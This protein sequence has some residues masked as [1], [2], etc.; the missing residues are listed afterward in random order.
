MSGMTMGEIERL[1]KTY[2]EERAALEETAEEVRVARRKA[3][4]SKL[5]VLKS[6]AARTSEAKGRLEAAIDASRPLFETRKTQAMHGIKFGLRK[7]PG[8][9]VGDDATILERIGKRLKDK[10]GELVRVKR[11]LDRAALRKLPA[12]ELA[13]IGASLVQ[14]DDEVFVAAPKS[15]IDK[16]VDALMADAEEGAA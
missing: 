12:N 15:D 9:I 4:A 3:A 16:F 14:D 11:E 10:A 7:K 8:R 6:R 1:A 5:H 2:A 13:A